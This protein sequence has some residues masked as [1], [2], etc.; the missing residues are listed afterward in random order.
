MRFKDVFGKKFMLF[1]GSTGTA[2][3]KAGLGAG[4]LPEEWNFSHPEQVSALHRAYIE[5]GCDVIATNT[6]GANP[7]K[8]RE[9]GMDH[10]AVIKRAV[11][12]AR[13]EAEKAQKQ[14][15]VALSAGPLGRLLAPLGDLGFEEAVSAF[16]EICVSARDAG[17]DL[18]LY[19]TFSDPYEMKAAL[20]A[21]RENTDLPVIITMM[22]GK[23]DRLISGGEPAAA[24]V[25]LCSMGVDG[26]GLNCGEGPEQFLRVLPRMMPYVNVPVL[27]S[28]N[29]GLPHGDEHG[30]ARYDV[31]PEEYAASCRKLAECGA[32]ALGGCCGTDSGYISRLAAEMSG[33]V[34]APVKN[35]ALT[36]VSSRSRVTEFGKKP[37]VIGE[38]INPTG[39][40]AMKAAL[41]ENDMSYI[42]REAVSQTAAGADILDINVGLPGIDEPAM[43]VRAVT[44]AQ[45]VTELPL[46]IDTADKTAL[47]KAL[48]VYNGKPLINSV[49]A[50]PASM[51]AV[52]PLV[53]KYGGA[54]VCLAMDDKTIPDTASGRAEVIG[55][56]VRRAAEYG[57]S[58]CDL[59]ADGLVTTAATDPE[60]GNKTLDTIELVRQEYGLC[61]ILGVSNISFGLPEREKLN[62]SFLSAAL[63]RGLSAAIMNPLS[64]PVAE[65]YR[66]FVNSGSYG[67]FAV[68]DTG[69]R[70]FDGG[71]VTLRS[72]VVFGLADQA[73]SLASELL[74]TASPMDIIN[75]ELI[76]ALDEV[77]AD[78]E[79]GK[80]FLPQLLMSAD[81][82]RSAFDVLK[83][84]YSGKAEGGEKII[85]AT[86][87]GDIHD[88]GKNIVKALLENYGYNV[89][90]LGKD[91][92]PETV[93]DA[94]ESTGA[95]LVGLSALMTTTVVNME[96]TIRL[97]HEKAP[98]CRV[99]VGGA[100]LNGEYARAI[101]ADYYAADAVAAVKCANGFFGVKE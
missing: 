34:P 2:L 74:L 61:S 87:Q 30:C 39:K 50:S 3:Q 13:A 6:F 47:E 37:I 98:Q 62:A 54:V 32:S 48:R 27:C 5:A 58:A 44:A 60:A 101:N 100:V 81:A 4:E 28:P 79:S 20:L 35:S 83:S 64:A 36:C 84:A 63:G 17:A 12:L 23:D 85:M 38:R 76:P 96:K 57:I 22:P 89:I 80:S 16:A 26:I 14:V 59:I 24:A 33:Y 51:D 31:T 67:E 43:L 10:D 68:G 8:M 88:I 99:M 69:V 45:K 90:D 92:A 75:G 46:Q 72:A 78:Y 70:K 11:A 71:D 97:L 15:F 29:A 65:S 53:K 82:A 77:G 91:V 40:S 66:S 93:L 42:M 95:R 1:D 49:N 55:R 94:V 9:R 86:V 19:E 56:I 21:A 41:R 25:M 7:F 52:F 73:A 18:I